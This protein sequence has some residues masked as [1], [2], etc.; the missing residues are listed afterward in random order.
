LGILLAGHI[1][2]FVENKERPQANVE[3][4]LFTESELR[5]S[6][7]QLYIRCRSNGS[8]CGCTTGHRHGHADDSRNRYGLLQVLLLC[9]WHSGNLHAFWEMVQKPF[10]HSIIHHTP[11]TNTLQDH[12]FARRP[13]IPIARAQGASEVA[14]GKA[15][16]KRVSA[17][18]VPRHRETA[19]QQ[20][21][22]RIARHVMPLRNACK[23]LTIQRPKPFVWSKAEAYRFAATPCCSQGNAASALVLCL[24]QPLCRLTDLAKE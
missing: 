10:A 9:L 19:S 6:I 23:R 8:C 13:G 3:H 20:D 1:N 11:C 4:F 12:H 21:V 18:L 7:L 24:P 15:V 22:G 17:K 5:W 2:F 14:P 16:H